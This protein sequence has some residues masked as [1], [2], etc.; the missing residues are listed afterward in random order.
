MGVNGL[1]M[2][3]SES[4]GAKVDGLAGWVI[5]ALRRWQR[6]AAEPRQM[7]VIE[8]LALGGRRQLQLVM[9]GTEKFLVAGGAESVHAILRVETQ[10]SASADRQAVQDETI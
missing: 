4:A 7:R 6:R 2:E 3:W 8:T 10:A 9:C 5:A 1:P